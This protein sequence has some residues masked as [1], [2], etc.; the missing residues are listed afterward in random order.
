M[1][2]TRVLVLSG[3]TFLLILTCVPPGV[4]MVQSDAS[5]LF[6]P[7]SRRSPPYYEAQAEQRVKI[8][9]TE[10]WREHNEEK[11]DEYDRYTREYSKET[12]ER[13]RETNEQLREF[14]YDGRYPRYHWF[15]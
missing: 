12:N 1:S 2:W 7:R 15:H 14:H 3:T 11:M 9:A 4:F 13:T 8:L 10:H 5:N 6:K